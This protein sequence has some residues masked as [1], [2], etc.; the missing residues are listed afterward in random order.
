MAKIYHAL[1]TQE[2][3]DGHR[4]EHLMMDT[5]AES[6]WEAQRDNCMP[7]EKK[8]IKRLKKLLKK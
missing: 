8:F 2:D 4:V 1:L 3:G 7:D 5:L 6:L